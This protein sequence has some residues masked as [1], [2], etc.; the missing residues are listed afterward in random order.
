[1]AVRSPLIVRSRSVQAE[2]CCAPTTRQLLDRG[3]A[4]GYAA[5]F[6]ALSDPTR[7]QIVRLLASIDEL[8]VCD[9]N[10]NFQLEASTMSHHLKTLRD[11]GLIS[12]TKRGLWVFY[13]LER[14][15]IE[16]TRQLATW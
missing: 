9:I 7:V 13:R 1:M 6:R 16:T 11:A 10:A 2:D 3:E 5:F 15:T 14:Q 8:C 12:S 4:D